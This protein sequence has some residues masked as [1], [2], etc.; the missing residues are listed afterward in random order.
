MPIRKCN[1][2]PRGVARKDGLD[3]AKGCVLPSSF[4]FLSCLQVVVQHVRLSLQKL[5]G[6]GTLNKFGP[7]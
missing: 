7:T 3:G 6:Q 1:S 4:V 2:M 5:M